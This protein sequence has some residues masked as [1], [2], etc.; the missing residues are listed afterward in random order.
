MKKRALSILEDVLDAAEASADDVA[1][2]ARARYRICLKSPARFYL[3]ADYLSMG[4]SFR[5]AS[6]I[7]TIT[8]ESTGWASLGSG[9]EEISISTLDSCARSISIVAASSRS[10]LD[11][12]GCD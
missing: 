1:D 7:L 2:I 10:R 6:R 4:V 5:M 8:E 3:I 9:S 12:L 11:I